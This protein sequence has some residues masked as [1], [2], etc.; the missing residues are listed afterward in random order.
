MMLEV[1]NSCLSNSL[2][3]NPNLIYTMLYQRAL[4]TGLLSHSTF[5]D[6]VT[7][8]DLVRSLV[9]LTTMMMMM[10]TLVLLYS[11]NHSQSKPHLHNA[12][13]ASSLHGTVVTQHVPGHCHKHWHGEITCHVNNDDDDDDDASI[14]VLNQSL[15]EVL[16][17]YLLLLNPDW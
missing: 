4:F 2:H 12:L 15:C 6:I 1:F 11:I 14:V 10:M 5:Q 16:P 8:I 7:N 9:M 13:S 17:S 3:H